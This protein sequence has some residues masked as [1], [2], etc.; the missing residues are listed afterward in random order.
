[1][2]NARFDPHLHQPFKNAELRKPVARSQKPKKLRPSYQLVV[3]NPR[4]NQ[5]TAPGT[6]DNLAPTYLQDG[7]TIHDTSTL[8]QS[9]ILRQTRNLRIT[10]SA[11]KSYEQPKMPVFRKPRKDPT[12]RPPEEWKIWKKKHEESPGFDFDLPTTET[13]FYKLMVASYARTDVFGPDDPM[14]VELRKQLGAASGAQWSQ[15][16]CS[17]GS[18]SD[19]KETGNSGT[20][21]DGLRDRAIEER[22]KQE[23]ERLATEAGGGEETN[24]GTATSFPAYWKDDNLQEARDTLAYFFPACPSVQLDKVAL[25]GKDRPMGQLGPILQKN[26]GIANFIPLDACLKERALLAMVDFLN[27]W[28]LEWYEGCNIWFG[29]EMQN[30]R[31]EITSIYKAFEHYQGEKVGN[32]MPRTV[33]DFLAVSAFTLRDLPDFDEEFRARCRNGNR[34]Y[35]AVEMVSTVGSGPL[36]QDDIEGMREV[37]ARSLA[38]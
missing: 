12:A 31:R 11:G 25:F 38:R 32:Q 14:E 33:H 8:M 1:M 16:M 17:F 2:V 10:T 19:S 13:Y 20:V 23:A 37:V 4:R 3:Y 26:P 9:E 28:Q 6:I 35:T 29:E 21:P 27:V 30:T 7:G 36:S 15:S 22:E 34:L 18:A 5:N 24:D